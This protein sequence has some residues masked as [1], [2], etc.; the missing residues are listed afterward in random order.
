ML[1]AFLAGGVIFKVLKEELPEERN[2]RYWTFAVG[3]AVY[4][5]LLLTL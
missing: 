1:F 5:V 3:L 2:S 4:I